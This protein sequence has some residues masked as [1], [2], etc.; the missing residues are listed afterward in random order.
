MADTMIEDL[1]E[2]EC[3]RLIAPGG[4]GRIAYQSRF[5]PAVLPVNYKLH[6]GAV[7]F[8][9]AQDSS[10]DQDLETGIAGAEY[11]VAFEIDDI[12]I[13]GRRGWSVL[14]QGSAH[15]VRTEA[16]RESVIEAGVE[17]WPGGQRELFV[18]IVPSRVT[19]RRVRPVETKS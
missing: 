5:G 9:T 19:G 2:D 7:L 16:E 1:G 11:R 18:R 3:L 10:L 8:R 12:D 15:R 14:I 4:V 6:D 13:P 17:P